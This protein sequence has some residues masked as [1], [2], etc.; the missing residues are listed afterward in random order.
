MLAT[1]IALAAQ[2]VPAT[3]PLLFNATT[4]TSASIFRRSSSASSHPARSPRHQ[5]QTRN[6]RFGLYWSDVDRTYHKELQRRHRIIKHKYAEAVEHKLSPEGMASKFAPQIGFGGAV[7]GLWRRDQGQRSRLSSMWTGFAPLSPSKTS[8]ARSAVARAAE[9][10]NVSD[11]L[12]EAERMSYPSSRRWP[13]RRE[14]PLGW[15]LYERSTDSSFFPPDDG[16]GYESCSVQ[17]DLPGKDQKRVTTET[18]SEGDSEYT[19]DPISNRRAYKKPGVGVDDGSASSQT[20]YI[21]VKTFGGYR[22]QFQNLQPPMRDEPRSRIH[23]NK[24]SLRLLEEVLGP[25]PMDEQQKSTIH[26]SQG[27]HAKNDDSDMRTH[28]SDRNKSA[29]SNQATF[30]MDGV[31]VGDDIKNHTPCRYNEP[32]GRPVIMSDGVFDVEEELKKYTPYR[33]NEPDGKF[34]HELEPVPISETFGDL[35]AEEDIKKYTPY[36]YNEPDGKFPHELEPMP[37]SEQFGDLSVEEDVGKYTPYK[38]NEPDGKFP[39]ELQPV[40]LSEQF[41]ELPVEKDIKS[42][43]PYK[44]NEPDGQPEPALDSVAEGLS[45]YDGRTVKPVTAEEIGLDHGSRAPPTPQNPATIIKPSFTRLSRSSRNTAPSPSYAGLRAFRN[46]DTGKPDIPP[47]LNAARDFLAAFGMKLNEETDAERESRREAFDAEFAKIQGPKKDLTQCFFAAKKG[48][49]A[50]LRAEEFEIQRSELLNHVAHAQGRVNARIAELESQGLLSTPTPNADRK[51]TG[52][53][54]QD[55]PEEFNTTWTTTGSSSNESLVPKNSDNADPW[56]YSQSPQGLEVSYQCE[57]KNEVQKAENEYAA[58]LASSDKYSRGPNADRLQTSLDREQASP[59]EIVQAQG[60]LYTSSPK[61]LELSYVKECLDNGNVEPPVIVKSYGRPESTSVN[62]QENRESQR[63]L[64]TARKRADRE[65]VRNLRAIYEQ[66]YGE[67][68]SKHRQQAASAN[69]QPKKVKVSEIAPVPNPATLEPILYKILA[70]DSTMQEINVA[71]TTSIMN[72]SSSA[73][74]P[75]EVLLRLSHPAKFFP[76]FKTLQAQGYE[77]ASGSG[78]VLVF[79]KVRET[80]ASTTAAETETPE[81]KIEARKSVNPI[82]GMQAT[83]STTTPPLA[84]TGNFASPT[85]FV[86]HDAFVTDVPFKSGIDVR[87]EEPVFS[88]RK[89]EWVEFEDKSESGGINAGKGEAAGKQGRRTKKLGKRLLLAALW[90]GACSYAVGLAGEY[91]TLV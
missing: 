89:H 74:T 14:K 10:P 45:E 60:D 61:G 56:G 57:K 7:C 36:R 21:P 88:G 49:D 79:R 5:Q 55:F 64:I 26:L 13:V 24:F 44:Y 76:H 8:S 65:L 9:T 52:N 46:R 37:I 47:T 59:K 81:P 68:N 77:I 62:T 31:L 84:A 85:G 71:E 4:I 63:E 15:G 66:P 48:K 39:H 17:K 58:G 43:K 90:V 34:P 40:Q 3:T 91:L 32:D 53:F 16:N 69:R 41:G 35:P 78:D 30:D 23:S 2:Q 33:Y 86:N 73:L 50:K 1:H 67:I 18:T 51:I 54:V 87:R 29:T 70:Y 83:L 80:A 42:Y 75:A 20:N 12:Q 38:Y 19:I 11:S 28:L 27:E 6:F 22:Y 82:D 72:D 25:G